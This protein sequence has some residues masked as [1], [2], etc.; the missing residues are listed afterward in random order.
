M[1]RSKN[2]MDAA[3]RA[4]LREACADAKEWARDY[5]TLQAAWE[6]CQRPDWMYWA[7]NKLGY[8]DDKKLRAFACW[9]VR[10]TPLADGRKVWDLL[11]DERSRRA[12]EVAEM[13]IRDEATAEELAAAWDAAWDAARAAAWDAAWAAARDA[14]WD[15]ARDA[16]RDAAWDA[17]RDA[18]RAAARAA[19]WDAAW[20]AQADALREIIG[21]PFV[22]VEPVEAEQ[23]VA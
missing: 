16:A 6:A 12:V 18:A 5:P 2:K 17:A 8:D 14:A 23:V 10:N 4:F 9:C 11:E 1:T 21:N 7:L 15:A 3:G 19:A 20:A 22:C 13:Y